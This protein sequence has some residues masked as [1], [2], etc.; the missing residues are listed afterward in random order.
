M[1]RVPSRYAFIRWNFPVCTLSTKYRDTLYTI[2]R[3][4]GILFTNPRVFQKKCK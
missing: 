3:Q 1:I 2:K 4:R